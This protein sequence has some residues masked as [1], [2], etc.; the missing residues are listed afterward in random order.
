MTTYRDPKALRLHCEQLEKGIRRD[1]QREEAAARRRDEAARAEQ[2]GGLAQLGAAVQVSA[3][4]G[5]QR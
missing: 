1:R 4:E 2:A 5:Q 3:I